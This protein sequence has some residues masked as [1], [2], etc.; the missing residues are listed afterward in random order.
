MNTVKETSRRDRLDRDLMCTKGHTFASIL[1]EQTSLIERIIT[2][3]CRD[4]RYNHP[5]S[6]IEYFHKDDDENIDWWRIGKQFNISTRLDFS[7]YGNDGNTRIYDEKAAIIDSHFLYTE[8]TTLHVKH[9]WRFTGS[10][11]E[12]DK[13]WQFLSSHDSC[14]NSNMM[15]EY[16]SVFKDAAL[17]IIPLNYFQHPQRSDNPIHV[18]TDPAPMGSMS[19][20]RLVAVR[21]KRVSRNISGF[22][23]NYPMPET[24]VP[25]KF[26]GVDENGRIEWLPQGLED[27][28]PMVE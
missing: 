10:K 23:D 1:Y 22:R 16:R 14:W 9:S 3:S 24:I 12:T 18:F 19:F 25:V 15:T 21:H 27:I 20:E 5:F 28:S 17:A 8:S 6:K 26:T 2:A 11:K 4:L 7:G 13:D